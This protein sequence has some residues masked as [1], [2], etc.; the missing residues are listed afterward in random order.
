MSAFDDANAVAEWRIR[1]HYTDRVRSLQAPPFVYEVS[2]MDFDGIA[3]RLSAKIEFTERGENLRRGEFIVLAM[4]HGITRVF[5][6]PSVID[7]A[8]HVVEFTQSWSVPG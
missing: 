1:D 8:I 3:R 5:M 7:G 4:S 6:S 2:P